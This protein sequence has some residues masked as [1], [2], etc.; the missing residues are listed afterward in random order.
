MPGCLAL[1][2]LRRCRDVA[3]VTHAQQ[4]QD[5]DLA[6][7]V[8]VHRGRPLLIIVTP[9]PRT[10]P[11]F[12]SR[13]TMPRHTRWPLL[14][15]IWGE[16][17]SASS[18]KQVKRRSVQAQQLAREVRYKAQL[19]LDHHHPTSKIAEKPCSTSALAGI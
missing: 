14:S 2:P 18:R 19:L 10:P 12:T 4:H 8:L 5:V 3:R 6:K 16:K 15:T 17:V 1:H 11:G 7:H 13:L 9:M